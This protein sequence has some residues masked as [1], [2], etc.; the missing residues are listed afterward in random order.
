MSLRVVACIYFALFIIMLGVVSAWSAREKS[1]GTKDQATEHFLGGR[2]TPF[3]VLAMAYCA[4]FASAGSFMGDPALVSYIGYPYI[5]FGCF[6]V[7]G[8]VLVGLVIIRKMRLQCEKLHCLTPIEFIGARFDSPFLKVFLSLT[9][10]ICLTMSL[11]SQVKGAAVLLV[12]FTQIDFKIA[13]III[14]VA[15]GVCTV[16]GGMRSVAWTDTFQGI[17]MVALCIVLIVS[18][19]V[20]AGGFAGIDAFLANY[21]PNMLKAA[22]D[23]LWADCGIP[24]IIGMAVFAILVL[25]AQPYLMS[26]YIA[27]KDVTRKTVGKFLLL[28][29]FTN[30][31]FCSLPI[32]GLAGRV[33]YPNAEADYIVVT[34]AT[35]ILH[36]LL[37]CGIMVGLFSAIIS[38][39]TAMLLAIGQGVGRDVLVQFQPNTSI[40]RQVCV[41]NIVS[42]IVV[43]ICMVFNLSNPPEFLQFFNLIGQTGVGT[44]IALPLYCGILYKK[45][46]KEA[47]ISSAIMG[48]IA[49]VVFNFIPCGFA[50]AMGAPIIVAAITF[51]GVNAIIVN[52]RGVNEE[53]A[54]LGQV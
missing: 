47:A 36:P 19:L 2:N 27:M 24:G 49:T 11:V 22:Q 51:F 3:F 9:M 1:K 25:P 13:V 39:A 41:A 38:T 53:I 54:A 50:V 37:S 28:M 15:I 8:S 52:A 43:L 16:S 45:A 44:A 18:G 20:K 21:D 42:V 7:P 40:K 6:L 5:W 46:T 33:L 10:A 17:L 26:N 12:H 14:A 31:L 35:G 48:V 29:L 4:S 34:L 32:C 30:L 23:G